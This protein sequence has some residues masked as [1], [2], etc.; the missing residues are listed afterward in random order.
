MLGTIVNVIAVLAGSMLGLLFKKGLPKSLSNTIMNGLALCVMYIGISGALSGQN[1]LMLIVAMVIGAIIGS[2][3]KL[4]E[5]IHDLGNKLQEKISHSGES[6]IAEGFVTSTLLFCVGAM[7]I[8]G[9]LQSGLTGDHSTI[10]TKSLIDFTSAII[11]TSQ[12]GIGVAFSAVPLFIYQGSIVL[13]ASFLSPVLSN[14]VIAEMS[15]VGYI[16]IVGLALNMLNLTKIK[17]MDYI[18]AIFLPIVLCLFM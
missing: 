18:P 16:I 3:L 17:V 12:F 13:L 4:D 6:S 7:S 8:V 9:S 1:S 2:L 5:R 15:C 10:Y 14:T 11:L